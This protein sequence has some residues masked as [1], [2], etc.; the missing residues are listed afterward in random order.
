MGTQV[1]DANICNSQHLPQHHHMSRRSDAPFMERPY[2]EYASDALFWGAA[3]DTRLLAGRQAN[4]E[5]V[6]AGDYL[7]VAVV[8]PLGPSA[9]IRQ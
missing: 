9:R 6:E 2:R 3:T 5:L 1:A 4:G 8:E 7:V